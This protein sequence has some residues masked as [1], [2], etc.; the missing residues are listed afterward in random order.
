MEGRRRLCK[1]SSRNG[2]AS[3]EEKALVD[4]GKCS[5][6]TDFESPPPPTQNLSKRDDNGIG[7][8]IRDILN[9]LSSRLELLSIEKGRG[10][11]KADADDNSFTL[12]E[13]KDTDREKEVVDIPEYASAGSSFSHTS[14]PSDSPSDETKNEGRGIRHVVHGYEVDGGSNCE[15]EAMKVG[16]NEPGHMGE[17]LEPA[18]HPFVSEIEEDEG[19]VDDEDDCVLLTSKKYVK[20]VVKKD[21]K[22]KEYYDSSKADLLDD[23]TDDSVLDDES[24]ITLTGLTYTYRLPGKIATMLY[25]HQCDGIRWLW[26]LH[27][28]GKGGI[29]GDDM[30]LGKTMQVRKNKRKFVYAIMYVDTFLE[31]WKLI[32]FFLL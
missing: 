16:K 4:D 14:D 2:N 13:S 30:G 6:I 24:S 25:P 18:V 8:E 29:L 9:D 20:K 31:S 5:D 22:V 28:Q 11:K 23:F 3:I 1:V 27:C 26:S 21:A 10:M 17:K 15:S 32:C 12:V 7:N 19:E